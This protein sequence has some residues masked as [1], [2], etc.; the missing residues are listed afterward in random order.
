MITVINFISVIIFVNISILYY[1]IS[2]TRTK[3]VF[4][5]FTSMPLNLAQ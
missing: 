1:N 5:S 4:G 3:T 2:C